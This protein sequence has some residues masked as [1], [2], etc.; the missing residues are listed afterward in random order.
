MGTSPVKCA[1]ERAVPSVTTAYQSTGLLCQL[2]KLCPLLCYPLC[3]F[4]PFLFLSVPWS[5]PFPPFLSKINIDLTFSSEYAT[6]LN[7]SSLSLAIA[8][9]LS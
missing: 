9:L 2:C 5:L 1:A 6:S 8:L 7:F 3:K 4:S